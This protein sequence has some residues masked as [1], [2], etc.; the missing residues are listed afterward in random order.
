[1]TKDQK[2]ILIALVIGDGTLRKPNRGSVQLEIGHSI[3][4]K[5]Y[6]KYKS[7][8][9]HSILGGNKP[10]LHYR[11]SNMGTK[12]VRIFK[13]HRYFRVIRRWLYKDNKKV[14]SRNILDKL[15]PQALAI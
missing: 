8:L 11:V 2:S 4:Q 3:K 12:T 13:T 10:N 14:I 6:I 7:D 5:E 1:M 15:T 9:L